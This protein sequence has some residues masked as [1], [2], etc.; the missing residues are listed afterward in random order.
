MVCQAFPRDFQSN[1]F[2]LRKCKLQLQHVRTHRNR[3][4]IRK[5]SFLRI[6]FCRPKLLN[7]YLIYGLLEAISFNPE[8]SS[9]VDVCRFGSHRESNHQRSFH[10]LVRVSSHD[11]SVLARSWLRLIGVDHEI[12]GSLFGWIF[13]HEGIL[14]S[15]G[16]AGSSSASEA[17]KLDLINYPVGPVGKDVF[18]S[19]PVA[20]S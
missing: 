20:L 13:R 18:C 17:G 4:P 7:F 12:A 5:H 3:S 14:K 8:L 1:L 2:I 19:M 11:L 9:H 16:K 6:P 10:E 15:G